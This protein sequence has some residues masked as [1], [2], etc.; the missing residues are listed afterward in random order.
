MMVTS[1][2]DKKHDPIIEGFSYVT[3]M[4]IYQNAW[5]E[6]DQV[7]KIMT[8]IFRKLDLDAAKLNNALSKK[9]H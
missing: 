8:D 9:D 3:K 2:K 7:I 5:L 1:T 4:L 6:T